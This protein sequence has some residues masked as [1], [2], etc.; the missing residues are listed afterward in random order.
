VCDIGASDVYAGLCVAPS[1]SGFAD[2]ETGDYLDLYTVGDDL[3]QVTG[4]AKATVLTGPHT[5]QVEVS[6]GVLS[7]APGDD[8]DGWEAAA[9]TTMWCPT[10]RLAICGLMG[11]C[12]DTLSDLA[13]GRPG[14]LRMRVSS[15][16]DDPLAAAVDT[17]YFAALAHGDRHRDLLT[18]A[19][20]ELAANRPHP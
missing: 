15:R 13:V 11:G 5:G 8:V 2:G 17:V 10:A 9:E 14:L 3:L 16:R 6:A 4:R 1:V 20:N 12:P 18:A 7:S 19:G